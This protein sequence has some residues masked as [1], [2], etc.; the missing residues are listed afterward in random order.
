MFDV[1]SAMYLGDKTLATSWNADMLLLLHAAQY[2]LT[3]PDRRKVDFAVHAFYKAE[4]QYDGVLR[5]LFS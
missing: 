1:F 5:T 2:Y 4:A 3:N